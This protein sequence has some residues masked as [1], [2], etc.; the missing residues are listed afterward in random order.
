MRRRRLRA[1]RHDVMHPTALPG[2]ASRAAALVSL[3]ALGACVSV[4]QGPTVPV[5]PGSGRSIEQYRADTGVCQQFAQDSIARSAQAAQ[6]NSA[7]QA[8]GGAA[9]GAVVGALIGGATGQAG[10]GAAWGAGSGLLVGS[11]AAGNVGAVSSQTLQRQFD[12]A[13]VQCMYARGNQVPGRVAQRSAPASGYQAMA[14][15]RSSPPVGYRA[16]ASAGIPPPGT[17][18]PPGLSAAVPPPSLRQ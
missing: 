18:A 1:R 17:S 11:A 6:D 10:A 15:A 7:S 13:Y 9:I 16:P 12:S 2:R 8:V 4:P 3:L 14:P 5:L